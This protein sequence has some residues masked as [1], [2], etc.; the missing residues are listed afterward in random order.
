MRNNAGNERCEEAVRDLQNRNVKLTQDNR[1]L[2][3][4]IRDLVTVGNAARAITSSLNIEEILGN[5]LNGIRDVLGMEKVL[6]C[7]VNREKQLEEAKLAVG[8]DDPDWQDAHWQIHEENRLW[9]R[10]SEEHLPVLVEPEEQLSDPMRG[11]FKHAFVKAPLVVKG[12][13]I[14]TIMA[15]RSKKRISARDLKLLRVFAEY[16]AI[17]IQNG[18]LYYDVIKS[19]EKLRETQT[20]LVEAERMAVVGQVAI[21]I[22]HEIN[23]PLSNIS[24]I[25]QMLQ[26]D[27][28]KTDRK[29]LK[30]LDEI[31]SNVKRIREVT[32]KI[33]ELNDVT[34]TEYLPN[35][36]MINL[37]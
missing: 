14:G 13:I 8:I 35:Q 28:R 33:F 11:I 19:K 29:L 1:R 5:V 30:L 34:A 7:L 18:R 23:N 22:N 27:L 9:Q 10:L 6:L 4:E 25:A 3:K 2:R 36:M 20:Q 12:H 31:D 37:K 16:T 17:S 21:S 26:K 32:H 15:Y 24:L